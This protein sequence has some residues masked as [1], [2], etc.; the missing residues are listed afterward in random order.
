[1]GLGDG[2]GFHKKVG[3]STAMCPREPLVFFQRRGDIL[4]SWGLLLRAYALI[5][6]TII[7]ILVKAVGRWQ[8]R[9]PGTR[10]GDKINPMTALTA[11]SIYRFW[12]SDA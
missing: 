11:S 9:Q 3:K 8:D 12:R 1:L 2:Q 4:L 5:A 6:M 10:Q 7:S